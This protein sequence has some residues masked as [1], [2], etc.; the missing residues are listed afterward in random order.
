MLKSVLRAVSVLLPAF[1]DV[2]HA[3]REGDGCG[4]HHDGPPW[5]PWKL[6]HDPAEGE[7]LQDGGQFP[8]PV[9]HDL[10]APVTAG[11]GPCGKGREDIAEDDDGGKPPWD[12]VLGRPRVEVE[13]DEGR[14]H[15]AFVREGVE[16]S[17]EP[18]MLLEAAGDPAVEG[19]AQPGGEEDPHGGEAVRFLRRPCGDRMAVGNREPRVERDHEDAEDRDSGGE[20]HV[21]AWR[22]MVEPGMGF[23]RGESVRGRAAS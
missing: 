10:D 5:G 17:A 16:D 2:D 19:I 23:V 8:G 9:G 12:P 21:A 14:Q 20:G 4:R 6:E 18:G 22:S 1:V 11:D 13:D 15:E 7:E 3:R